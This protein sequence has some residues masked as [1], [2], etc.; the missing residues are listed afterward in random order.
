M[1]ANRHIILGTAGHVDHGKTELVRA[2]TGINTDRLREEQERGISIELGFAEMVLPSG[3]RVG[4]VDVPGHERFVKAMVAGAAGMD[5][6]LLVVAADESVMPQ[7]RE[8]L[9]IMALLGLRGGVVAVTKCDLVDEETAEI[10]EAEIEDLVQG[11]FLEGARVVRTSAR[12]RQGLDDLLSALEETT[13][14]LPAKPTDTFFRLP[15]DRAFVLPGVGLVV[16]GTAWSGRVREG[17]TVEVLPLQRR[18]RVRSVQVHGQKRQEALA[19]ERVAINLHGFK[20]EELERG[21]LVA[22]PEMLQPSYMIDAS[23]YLL[24]S[25]K[26]ALRNRTRVRVHHGAAEVFGRVVLLDREELEPGDSGPAQLRLEQPLATDREDHIVLR[27]YSPMRTIGG[28]RVLDPRPEK[29]RRFRE[30]VLEEFELKERGSPPDLL[31]DLIRRGGVDGV[32]RAALHEARVLAESELDPT[33]GALQEAERIVRVGQVFYDVDVL[34]RTADT[35]RDL[36]LAHQRDNAL[37][38]GIGRAELQER[39]GHRAAR[40]RFNELLEHLAAERVGE[41]PI[42]LRS[43]AVR[44]G[45]GERELAAADRAALERI[46]TRL[47]EG[48]AAPPTASELQKELAV[49]NRFPAFASLLEERGVLVK[50]TESLLYHADALAQI[51]GKL[52]QFLKS[53]DVMSMAEFK[54]LTGLTRKYTVPLLEYFDRQGITARDGDVRRPGPALDSC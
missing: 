36:A 45:S 14:T 17:D 37:S 18:A 47:R 41:A 24:P 25:F 38:W 46:E 22:T 31:H 12:T 43:D 10:V 21:M 23:I 54:Q 49:G 6:G 13:A 4:L 42:H 51:E 29:H 15:V 9:D 20:Q 50:V 30:D 28:A 32:S 39:L 53:R 1:H 16:T 3:D 40:A 5:L 34:A 19:G 48:G 33:L 26:R 52:R 44:V 2:L 27:F 7:T 35:I 11:T 8:H